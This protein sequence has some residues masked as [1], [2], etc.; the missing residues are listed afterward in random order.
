MRSVPAEPASLQLSF[1]ATCSCWA[2]QSATVFSCC[3]RSGLCFRLYLL[4]LIIIRSHSRTCRSYLQV[5]VCSWSEVFVCSWN[6]VSVSA[7]L[8]VSVRQQLPPPRARRLTL[9]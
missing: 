7:C 9:S 4:F 6:Q 1:T 8:Q 5:S 3:C 2:C